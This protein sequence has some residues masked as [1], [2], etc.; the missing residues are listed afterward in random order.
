V[1]AQWLTF[2]WATLYVPIHYVYDVSIGCLK[3][4]H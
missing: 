1:I 3:K 4:E 2:Y